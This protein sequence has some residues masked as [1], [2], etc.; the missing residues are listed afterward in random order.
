MTPDR[1]SAYI[2]NLDRMQAQWLIERNGVAECDP[3][4]IYD[5][6]LLAYQDEQIA[7]NASRE[8]WRRKRSQLVDDFER[9]R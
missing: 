5:I 9:R 1:R 4:A 2:G 8:A 3:N 6:Y 7:E